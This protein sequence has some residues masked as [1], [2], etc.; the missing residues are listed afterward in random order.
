MVVALRLWSLFA[1]CS[2]G[3]AALQTALLEGWGVASELTVYWWFNATLL[4]VYLGLC[5]FSFWVFY[6]C[7]AHSYGL[8]RGILWLV[9]FFATG[10]IGTAIYLLIQLLNI[11]TKASGK[12]LAFKL[13]LRKDHN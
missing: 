5:L 10:N 3:Y 2:M 9:F 12:E 1:I 4:D 11:D 13:L 7:S 8:L 6:K